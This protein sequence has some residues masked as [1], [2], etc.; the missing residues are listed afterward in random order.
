MADKMPEMGLKTVRG[1]A[2]LKNVRNLR[3]GGVS[4]TVMKVFI[5]LLAILSATASHAESY[6]EIVERAFD[7]IEPRIR[8]H[9]AFTQT[10]SNADGVYVARYDPRRPD[11]AM[12]E[13]LTV[14]DREPTA[15]ERDDFLADKYRGAEDKEGNDDDERRAMVS[16]SSVE[17]VEESSAYWIFAFKPLADSDDEA[18]FMK[19]VDARLRVVKDGHYVS[20]IT[21]VNSRPIKPGKG[22]KLNKFDVS[23]EFSLSPN[24][25]AVLPRSVS[26]RI[27]GRAML[28]VGFDEDENVE[29]SDYQRVI[30]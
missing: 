26:T 4:K 11:G 21:M 8:D 14:D 6:E 16:P 29:F 25:G 18:G 28:I 22:V 24:G 1:F 2:C 20:A 27:K 5:T 10:T 23:M 15:E 13:L 3:V 9:W 19:H 12:W 30:N 7:A 17:L